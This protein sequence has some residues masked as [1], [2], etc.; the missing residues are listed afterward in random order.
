M[1]RA[2]GAFDDPRIHVGVVCASIGCPMLRPEA[3]TAEKLDAQLD[4]G[5]KRFL[6][7]VRATAT[8]PA[9]ASSMYRRSSTGTARISKRRTKA[10]TA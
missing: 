2:P 5:M 1:I 9:A 8:T 7:T 3:F 4:D 10:T 6:P